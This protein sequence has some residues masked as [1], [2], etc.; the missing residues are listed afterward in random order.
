MPKFKVLLAEFPY[1]G[2]VCHETSDWIVEAVE[3]MRD[4]PRIGKDGVFRWSI[5]DT[6]ITLGRNRCLLVA[7]KHNI[8]F[9]LMIDS[10][11]A[12]DLLVGDDPKALP[13]WPTAWEFVTKHEGPCVIAAPYCGPPP[14]EN[15]FLFRF[16]N[17]QSDHPGIDFKLTQ[18]TRHEAAVAVGIERVAALPTGLML[19]DMRAVKNLRHPR[20]YYEWT[21]ETQA[22][23]AST[24]DVTFS[25]DLALAG[26]PL[27]VA[28]DCWAGHVKRKIVGK[29]TRIAAE[30]VREQFLDEARRLVAVEPRCEETTLIPGSTECCT[31]NGAGAHAIVR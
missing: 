15:P 10:D 19:I 7:E 6:P 1:G 31:T 27:W 29:P 16:E 24:E 18:F 21:D 30:D 26:V 17:Q 2:T 25:R 11:L 22:F 4:D 28:W 20:F 5:N 23:K 13:F 12:P 14:I 3:S 8:D 9:V